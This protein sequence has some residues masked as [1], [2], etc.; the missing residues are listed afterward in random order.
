MATRT[1]HETKKPT[2]KP[3]KAHSALQSR[4]Q[5]KREKDEERDK[6]RQSVTIKKTPA[7]VF[8]FWRNFENLPFFMKDLKEV[9]EIS[10]KVSHWVVELKNGAKVE[11]DAEIIAE[12]E[13]QMISWKSIGDSE[14]TQTGTVWFTEAPS[15]LGTVVQLA[16]NYSV[17]GGKVTELITKLSG[18]DPET[19]ILTNLRRL[20]AYLETGEIPTTEGQPSGRDEDSHT[21]KH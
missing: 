5:A 19:L 13:D 14:V 7:Q 15:N 17:P 3:I 6:A 8:A 11:W 1:T 12:R 16:M 20:K 9:T 4:T 21:V 2:K 18:E 10:K